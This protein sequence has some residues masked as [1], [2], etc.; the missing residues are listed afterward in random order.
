MPDTTFLVNFLIIPLL[1]PLILS[2][3]ISRAS[4][5]CTSKS[6]FRHPTAY[7]YL[8][9]FALPLCVI[10]F[11]GMINQGFGDRHIVVIIFLLSIPIVMGCLSIYMVLCSLCWKLSLDEDRLIYRNFFG[12]TKIY[13]YD[14]ITKA[15]KY[16]LRDS[17]EPYKFI[18]CVCKTKIQIEYTDVNFSR[19]EYLINKRLKKT[20]NPVQFE[21]IVTKMYR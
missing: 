5:T 9:I 18:V 7:L 11:V 1:V 2:L 4:N 15:C 12:V 21:K 14:N 6:E 13:S 17:K 10:G 3:V 8:G 19:F 16:Y 20:K